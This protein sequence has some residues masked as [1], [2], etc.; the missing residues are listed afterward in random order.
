MRRN[1][2]ARSGGKI[3]P[4]SVAFYRQLVTHP[5]IDRRDLRTTMLVALSQIATLAGA[6]S[7]AISAGRWSGSRATKHELVADLGDASP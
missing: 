6:M 5:L 4:E 2:R 7:S 1:A 3:V